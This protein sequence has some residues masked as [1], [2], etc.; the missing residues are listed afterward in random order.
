MPKL[1][2]VTTTTTVERPDEDTGEIIT[3]QTMSK[4]YAIR[5]TGPKFF[6]TFIE[7]MGPLSRVRSGT[8]RQVL[9]W[10]CRNAVF[11][12]G[13]VM[14]PK[15]ERAR[16]IAELDTTKQNVYASLKR[17]CES[18]ILEGGDGVFVINPTIFWK[19]AVEERDEMIRQNGNRFYVT[20]SLTP[21]EQ[22]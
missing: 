4:T 20:Y 12:T 19:G 18:G 13:R 21:P 15:A 1:K 10:L 2:N 16:M 8:D 6:M 3:E 11:N 9:D 14:L 22:A 17:L 7:Y 5:T